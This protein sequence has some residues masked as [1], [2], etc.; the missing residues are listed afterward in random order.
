MNNFNLTAAQKTELLQLARR[1][2]TI[3]LTTGKLEMVTVDDPALNQNSGVFVTLWR[4]HDERDRAFVDP[5]LGLRGCIG[6]VEAD[7]PMVDV[8]QS[9]AVSAATNDPR[10]APVTAVELPDIRIEISVLSPLFLIHNIEEIEVGKHGL[11]IE[12]AR[13]RGLLLPDV[14]TRRG[15]SRKEFLEALCYKAALPGGCWQQRGAKLYGFT[16]VTFEEE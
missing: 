8:V 13:R 11:V 7:Q 14:P 1:A 9:M 2:I 3:F 5:T 6:H 15:W 10:F 16:T 12:T 4:Q